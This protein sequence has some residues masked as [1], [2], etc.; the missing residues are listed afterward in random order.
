M[1][2]PDVVVVL[3]TLPADAD[4]EDF[5]QTLVRERLAACVSV[6][7]EVHSIYRWQGDICTSVERQC[8]IKT[9]RDLLSALEQRL[10]ALHPYDV[11]EFLAIPVVH[12]ASAYLHWVRESTRD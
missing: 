12:G 9:R 8:L 5:G 4:V 11:P 7:G 2:D 6:L 1:S 3:T 10:G